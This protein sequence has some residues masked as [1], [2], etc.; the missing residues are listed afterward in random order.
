ME[1]ELRQEIEG[2]LKDDSQWE[3][4][5]PSSLNTSQRAIIHEIADE[6]G[7]DH[8]S[9]G[10]GKT[11]FIK[12]LKN[13]RQLE[14]AFY[15]PEKQSWE[16]VDPDTVKPIQVQSLC[17]LTFNVLFDP[18]DAHMPNKYDIS[19]LLHSSIRTVE[20]FKEL[21]KSNA[22]FIALQEVTPR[23]Q[24]ELMQED[25]LRQKYIISDRTSQSVLPTGNLILSKYPLKRMNIYTY[26]KRCERH[27]H[28]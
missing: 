23:L 25:W 28:C 19:H 12:I 17:F 4:H 15:D 8:R 14:Q 22:D 5:F 9:S 13:P 3:K 6:L 10:S 24:K 16:L 18:K 2:F 1:V 26:K 11:R 20:L 21:G 7:L 27:A